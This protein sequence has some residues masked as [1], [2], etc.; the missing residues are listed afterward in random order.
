MVRGKASEVGIGYAEKGSSWKTAQ[1]RQRSRWVDHRSELVVHI[2][3]APLDRLD[4]VAEQTLLLA[5][6]PNY[7]LAAECEMC[8]Y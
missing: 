6:V 2:A 7:F 8:E 4:E 3:G 5:W 1:T